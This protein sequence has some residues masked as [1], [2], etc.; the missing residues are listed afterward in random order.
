MIRVFALK[1][2]LCNIK[3]KARRAR[4]RLYQAFG[5]KEIR[6]AWKKQW[7]AQELKRSLTFQEMEMKSLDLPILG[8]IERPLEQQVSVVIVVDELGDGIVVTA[9]KHAGGGLFLVD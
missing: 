6:H 9:G 7:P 5:I 3:D 2:K 4:G 8:D 1:E